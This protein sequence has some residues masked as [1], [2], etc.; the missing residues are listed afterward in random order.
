MQVVRPLRLERLAFFGGDV[1]HALDDQFAGARVQ[2]QRP[3]QRIGSALSGVIVGRGTNA[4]AR[5][6]HI[7]AGECV[8]QIGG[9][10]RW[11]IANAAHPAERQAAR[12][13]QLDH[14][15]EMLVRSFAREDFIADDQQTECHGN[16]SD[17]R[18]QGS[19][20]CR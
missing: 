7:A 5:K 6:D 19:F 20:G 13:E 1:A 11:L 3:T 12:T 17:G 18:Q 4:A 14:L 16:R 2:H 10:A 15:G 9:D 8:L